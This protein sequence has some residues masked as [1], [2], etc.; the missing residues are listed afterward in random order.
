MKMIRL[1]S[2]A[3]I[4]GAAIGFARPSYARQ[5]VDTDVAQDYGRNAVRVFQDY[6]LKAGDTAR[7]VVV[8][9]GSATIDGHVRGDV[10]VVIGAAHLWS[11]GVADGTMTGVAGVGTLAEG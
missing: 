1:V 8:I 9:S 3:L 6:V 7:D 5:E 2:F 4:V 10:V 11:T